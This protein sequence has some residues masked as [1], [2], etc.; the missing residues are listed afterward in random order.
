MILSIPISRGSRLVI[1]SI[2]ECCKQ[3][4]HWL[5]EKFGPVWLHYGDFWVENEWGKTSFAGILW[6]RICRMGRSR[7]QGG[8]KYIYMGVD[9]PV[10]P[11]SASQIG[12]NPSS[13][14]KIYIKNP[15]SAL[16]PMWKSWLIFFQNTVSV[17][18]C[19]LQT[20]ILGYSLLKSMLF[21]YLVHLCFQ[22][23]SCSS[24][25]QREIH[26]LFS[27]TLDHK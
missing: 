22:S 16:K 12:K 2:L 14:L 9:V 21:Y 11:Q 1:L 26:F 25:Y 8:P 17:S 4:P 13:A 3:F 5:N 20:K 10:G 15:T 27:Q 18:I 19:T 24:H 23:K 7:E 6:E